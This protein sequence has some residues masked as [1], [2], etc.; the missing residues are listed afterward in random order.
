MTGH[1]I[2]FEGPEGAGKTTQVQKMAEIFR[3]A[4]RE[5]IVTREPGGTEIST[6]IR[7][8][9]LAAENKAMTSRTEL[10][11]YAAD[12]AQHVDEKIRPALER[13]AVVLCD[14]YVDST[15]AY[16][17]FGRGLDLELIR[18]LCRIATAGLMPV[19]TVLVDLPPEVGMARAVARGSADTGGE[20][21]RIEAEAMDFHHRVREGFLSLAGEEPARVQIVNGDQTIE[22]I[23]GDIRAMMVRQG[24]LAS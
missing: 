12:R 17:G 5:V 1:F 3:A 6:Q 16:Q 22:E 8:I 14:R 15:I 4:G 2:T 20:K 19:L 11:L 7:R 21:D 13:G 18:E 23:H 10:L 9:L 24:I